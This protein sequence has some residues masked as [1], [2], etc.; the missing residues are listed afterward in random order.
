MK[1]PK[2]AWRGNLEQASRAYPAE[3]R[4][5]LGFVELGKHVARANMQALPGVREPHTS[6]VAIQ[7][8]H[9]QPRFK[10]RQSPADRRR[11]HACRPRRRTKGP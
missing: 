5:D 4:L 6:R 10:C 1:A 9:P 11:L 7:E 2:V 8:T 3:P